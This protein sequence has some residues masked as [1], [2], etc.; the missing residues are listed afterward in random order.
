MRRPLVYWMRLQPQ[1]SPA[2]LWN[3]L[4]QLPQGHSSVRREPELQRRPGSASSRKDQP[5]GPA[6]SDPSQTY[7]RW[8]T[9]PWI[10]WSWFS[11]R[12][13]TSSGMAGLYQRW[14]GRRRRHCCH[15]WHWRRRAARHWRCCLDRCWPPDWTRRSPAPRYRWVGA[16]R[17]C[18]AGEAAV[19]AAGALSAAV[20]WLTSAPKRSF[21]GGWPDRRDHCGAAWYAAFAAASE[22][23]LN[24][25]RP[26]Q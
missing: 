17:R 24:T 5:A 21:A 25:G 18:G 26:P 3:C 6:R 19:P 8:P 13:W 10:S 20:F 23:T 2:A 12:R 16:R 7:L 1:Q 11:G 22:V 15:C 14:V 9:C 4:M